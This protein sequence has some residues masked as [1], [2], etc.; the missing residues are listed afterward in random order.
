M[1][2]L[3]KR[4]PIVKRRNR[5]GDKK[6]LRNTILHSR[7]RRRRPVDNYSGGRIRTR[8]GNEFTEPREK[9]P[10]EA[11]LESKGYSETQ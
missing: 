5:E 8:T 11:S 6:K 1:G 4:R 7:G 2:L 9:K 3:V 10:K